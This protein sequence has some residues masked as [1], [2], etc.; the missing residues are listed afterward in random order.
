MNKIKIHTVE[1]GVYKQKGFSDGPMVGC[2]NCPCGKDKKGGACCR[3]GCDVD[4]ESYELI[5]KNRKL[6]EK[7]LGLGKAEFDECFEKKWSGDKEFFGGDSI[8]AKKS[9]KTGYCV[10]HY[11]DKKGCALVALV[12]K[13]KLNWRMVPTICK[14]YPITWGY[15]VLGIYEETSEAM[16]FETCDCNRVDNKTKKTVWET[17]KEYIEDIFDIEV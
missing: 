13:H 16:D 15:G 7:E 6:V 14:L 3:Y 5:Y 17:Q 1:E 4:K 10:F 9:K 8:R 2:L 11:K 12:L